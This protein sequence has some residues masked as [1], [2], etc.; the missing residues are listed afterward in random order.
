M[1]IKGELL[2]IPVLLDGD[3]PTKLLCDSFLFKNIKCIIEP[4]GI[5][6]KEQLL[7]FICVPARLLWFLVLSHWQRCMSLL[8]LSKLLPIAML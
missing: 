7:G 6:L 5:E 2:H 3:Y 4:L 1:E 8:E